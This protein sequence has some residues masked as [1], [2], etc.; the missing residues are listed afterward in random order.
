LANY[1]WV[2]ASSAASFSA[3]SWIYFTVL[4][5][6]QGG[7]SEVPQGHYP[8]LGGYLETGGGVKEAYDV[9]NE[10]DGAYF[11]WCLRCDLALSLRADFLITDFEEWADTTTIKN[12]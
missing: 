10:Y 12:N 8:S 2:L 1:S 7:Q 9:G 3:L 5:K 11:E 6:I 4:A